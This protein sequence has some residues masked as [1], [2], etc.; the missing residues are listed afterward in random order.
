MNKPLSGNYLG[1]YEV[2]DTSIKVFNRLAL[3][4][5]FPITRAKWKLTDL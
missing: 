5:V 1:N 2:T 4:Y 3:V